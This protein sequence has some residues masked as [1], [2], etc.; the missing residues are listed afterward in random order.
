MSNYFHLRVDYKS[1]D[2]LAKNI[3]YLARRDGK[4]RIVVLEKKST[5]GKEHFHAIFNDSRSKSQVRNLWREKFP[6]YDGRGE[7]DYQLVSIPNKK[8]PSMI[9]AERY[10]CK[11][12]SA[13]IGPNVA[14]KTG[15]YTD[16]YIA[17]RHAEYWK[18]GGPKEPDVKMTHDC[19]NT[20]VV[21]QSQT[22]APRKKAPNFFQNVI[23]HLELNP[24]M[25]G[26][27][28]KA[29]DAP[30][31]LRTLIKF[32]GQNFKPYGPQQIENEMNLLL[33]V[34]VFQDHYDD[35]YEK[36]RLRGQIPHL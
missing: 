27:A 15:K 14:Y 34:L 6:D 36:I 35:I 29:T 3:D 11:G 13:E 31:I 30:Y 5:N 23:A 2:D 33:N 21:P 24:P 10:L 22:K 12:D 26:V 32:H 16:E 20:W 1:A 8:N 7:H 9:D 28:Y 18:H 4:D 17:E 25:G 19:L